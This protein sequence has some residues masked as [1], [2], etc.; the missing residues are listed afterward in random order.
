MAYQI[1]IWV[2]KMT[3]KQKHINLF[4]SNDVIITSFLW[5]KYWTINHKHIKLFLS[6]DVVIRFMMKRSYH[7]L[8]FS[9]NSKFYLSLNTS[10]LFQP[11]AD[12]CYLSAVIVFL[13]FILGSWFFK[14]SEYIDAS[15][16]L[17]NI[18]FL[19]NTISNYLHK[20][21]W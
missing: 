15:N 14:R 21:K 3:L 9:S 20:S 13:Q 2:I 17:S 19:L 18:F 11:L 1:W 7:D 6:N 5:P 4:L 12:F 8:N 16:G 10:K